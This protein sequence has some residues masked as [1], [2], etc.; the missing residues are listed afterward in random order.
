MSIFSCIFAIGGLGSVSLSSLN[1]VSCFSCYQPP[2]LLYDELG[3][4]CVK[5]YLASVLHYSNGTNEVIGREG[6][7]FKEH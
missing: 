4:F 6:F 7:D 3:L 1:S 5:R 2:I